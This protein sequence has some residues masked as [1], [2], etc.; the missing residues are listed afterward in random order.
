[1]NDGIKQSGKYIGETGERTDTALKR[2]APIIPMVERV[3]D[4]FDAALPTE[5]EFHKPK[6]D[7]VVTMDIKFLPPLYNIGTSVSC[8]DCFCR[9]SESFA[10]GSSTY[11]VLQEYISGTVNVYVDG[12][13]TG[14]FTESGANEITLN[15]TTTVLNKIDISYVYQYT[16]QCDEGTD[17]L[18]EGDIFAGLIRSSAYTGGVFSGYGQLGFAGN[19][20]AYCG[21]GFSCQHNVGPISF[22]ESAPP[23][24]SIQ[25]HTE[26][27]GRIQMVV[28]TAGV[29]IPAV[30]ASISILLN[31]ATL[32]TSAL[33]LGPGYW[34]ATYQLDIRNHHFYDGD[35][36]TASSSVNPVFWTNFGINITYMHVGRGTFPSVNWS[37]P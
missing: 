13:S 2:V 31:G 11:T 3:R 8:G 18:Y 29:Y 24:N 5:M 33:V 10:G 7:T 27:I 23:F 36:I 4:I 35:I 9:S 30:N 32:A 6:D 1:M 19:R 26:F 15:D 17:V 22:V 21:G 34:P 25:V 20:D 14:N 16:D 12:V 37:G 28:Q